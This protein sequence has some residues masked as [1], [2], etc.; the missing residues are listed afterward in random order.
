MHSRWA[1]AHLF[2]AVK[3]A[4]LRGGVKQPKDEGRSPQVTSLSSPY[5][6][7]KPKSP[8]SAG[9]AVDPTPLDPNSAKATKAKKKKP[10]SSDYR[11]CA[12]GLSSRLPDG[13]DNPLKSCARCGLVYYCGRP[14]QVGNC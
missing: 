13:S 8:R 14:C 3:G 5:L 11:E 2:H 10:V 1:E 12:S 6:S 4:A 9:K 7:E